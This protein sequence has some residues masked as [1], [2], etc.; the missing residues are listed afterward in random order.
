MATA[1]DTH[2]PPQTPLKLW[3]RLLCYCRRGFS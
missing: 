3:I 2:A 1:L